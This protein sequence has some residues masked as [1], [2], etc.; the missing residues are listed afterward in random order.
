M[1]I[2]KNI[3]THTLKEKSNLNTDFQRIAGWCEAIFGADEL[4]LEFLF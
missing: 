3:Y 2:Q 4:A 1:T